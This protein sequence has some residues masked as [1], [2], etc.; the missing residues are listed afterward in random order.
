MTLRERDTTAQ[1]IG[2]IDQVIEVIRKLC[3][4]SLDWEGACKELPEYSGQQDIDE[5]P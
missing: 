1:R 5:Q 4:G 3:D 2:P